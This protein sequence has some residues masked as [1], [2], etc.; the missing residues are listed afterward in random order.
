MVVVVGGGWDS[1]L[2][3]RISQ[4]SN[5]ELVGTKG[6]VFGSLTC[7]SDVS[8]RKSARGL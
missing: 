4:W 7:V 8:V 6:G 3:M 1:S 5:G 2:G